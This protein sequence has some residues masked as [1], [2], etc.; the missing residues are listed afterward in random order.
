MTDFSKGAAYIDGNLVPISEAKISILDW[1]FLHSDATYDVVHV[2]DGKF[3]RLDDHLERFFTGM[4]KLRMSIPH[5]REEV[6]LI[7]SNCVRA[8]ELREAYVE[9]ITTRG[10]PKPGSRDPRTCT[11]QFFAFV[12]PFVWIKKPQ[13]GLDLVVSNRQRIPAASVDP[14]VK[15]YHWLDLVMGQFEAYDRGGETAALIDSEG[16]IMEGPGFNIFAIKDSV[17]R[18]P[19]GGV[20]EG[21]TRKTVVE[22]AAENGYKVIQDYLSPEFARSADELFATS[23]AGGIMPITTIDGHTI[24]NGSM[25]PITQQLQEA[26]WELHRNPIYTSA[27]E[28]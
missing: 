23:T 13:D 17:L 3:F 14:I 7:L 15:N 12:I 2:W 19:A 27:I 10:M 18:T 20:L 21:I 22:L 6:G 11:N 26:Y 1:G 9:M 24:G 16:N 4:D 5:T 8:S 25:G 28:Y